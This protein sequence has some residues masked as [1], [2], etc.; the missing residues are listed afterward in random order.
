MELRRQWE[1]RIQHP[2]KRRQFRP[3]SKPFSWVRLMRKDRAVSKHPKNSGGKPKGKVEMRK[4]QPKSRQGKQRINRIKAKRRRRMKKERKST[5]TMK[6]KKYWTNNQGRHQL[7]LSKATRS[8][9]RGNRPRKR[10]K[11]KANQSKKQR[12]NNNNKNLW[13]RNNIQK[14]FWTAQCPLRTNCHRMQGDC[15]YANRIP[16]PMSM[17]SAKVRRRRRRRRPAVAGWAFPSPTI[18][19][20]R[21]HETRLGGV[22]PPAS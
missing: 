11:P 15:R 6:P 17:G 4:H 12:N 10:R 2:F 16:S 8:R 9:C 18:R 7:R 14:T 3:A 21:H 20:R 19:W 5:R 13:R 1:Q 22:A